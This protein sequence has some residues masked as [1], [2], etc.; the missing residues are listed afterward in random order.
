MKIIDIY[1]NYYS[2]VKIEKD[3]IVHRDYKDQK[4]LTKEE[5]KKIFSERCLEETPMINE[6]SRRTGI[7]RRLVTAMYLAESD[8]MIEVGLMT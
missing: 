2:G 1:K 6:I 4:I 3:A 8:I 7:P 5:K